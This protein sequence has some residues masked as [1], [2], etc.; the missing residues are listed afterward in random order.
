M[1]TPRPPLQ[2]AFR[3][4]WLTGLLFAVSV[5]AASAGPLREWAEQRRKEKA[6]ENREEDERAVAR[7]QLP[8]GVTLQ[9]NV[10]YGSDPRQRLD[11]YLPASAKESAPIIFMVH[12]GAWKFGDKGAATVVDHKIQRWVTQGFIFVSVNYRMLPDATP[13]QQADD[14][15]RALAYVQ[16]HAA[17]YHG[18]PARVVLMGHSAGAHLVALI[19]AQPDLATR[20]GAKPWLGTVA[21]DSACYDVTEIMER[22]HFKFY[23]EAFGKDP[24]FWKATSPI[25][26]LTNPVRPIL[27]VCS[28]RRD[29]SPKQARQFAAHAANIGSSV[30]VLPEDLSHKEINQQL[31]ETGAYTDA[32]EKFLRTLD[33]VVAAKLSGAN[34][35]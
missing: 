25:S 15:A 13:L 20:Q 34:R 18:D 24:A 28:T 10:A 5:G 30:T 12:G 4:L 14:V 3:R 6:Q 8:T 16:A 9:A 26:L 7:P 1:A 35:N 22:R 11:V 21:L 29:D 33:P 32:V 31:G 23:D 27:A 17:D 2:S 19:S